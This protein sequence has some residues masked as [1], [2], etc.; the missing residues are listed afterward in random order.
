MT[1]ISVVAERPVPAQRLRQNNRNNENDEI[2]PEQ[3]GYAD[4]HDHKTYDSES[5]SDTLQYNF[6]FFGY[7]II[8]L[9]CFTEQIDSHQSI[10][11]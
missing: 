8:H 2:I 11:L 10:N 7:I 9:L 5:E 6:F 1:E 4:A 3:L